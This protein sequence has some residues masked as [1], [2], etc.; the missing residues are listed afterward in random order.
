MESAECH[1]GKLSPELRNEVYSH[2]LPENR[3]IRLLPHTLPHAL[4]SRSQSFDPVQ[5]PI[6][7]VCRQIRSETKPMLYGNNKFVLPLT[8]HDGGHGGHYSPGLFRLSI[9][10]AAAWL[11]RNPVDRS[12]VRAPL[13]I[14]FDLKRWRQGVQAE[15]L[16]K[17][18]SALRENGYS[19]D[20]SVFEVF[21]YGDWPPNGCK[22]FFSKGSLKRRAATISQKIRESGF[23][24]EPRYY[25]L[26]TFEWASQSEYTP[27]KDGHS[28]VLGIEGLQ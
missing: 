23:R 22:R 16:N 27:A 15:P 12:P 2:L 9:S 10:E 26:S 8:T 24:C 17:L 3:T 20:N 11:K 19:E 1:F 13:V 5:P 4:S 7:R 6:T 21:V 28:A 18:C 25:G 14:A